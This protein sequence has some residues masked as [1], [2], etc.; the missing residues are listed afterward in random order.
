MDRAEE[1]ETPFKVEIADLYQLA[2]Q[3]FEEAGRVNV[4]VSGNLMVESLFKAVSYT[5]LDVYKR[6]DPKN[7]SYLLIA[8]DPEMESIIGALCFFA[9]FIE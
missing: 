8:N 7:P 5:H 4:P 9:F 3:A 6:Q 1:L 2:R